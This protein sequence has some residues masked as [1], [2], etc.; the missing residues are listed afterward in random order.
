MNSKSFEWPLELNHHFVV[1][2]ASHRG[3]CQLL[4]PKA[5]LEK[6]SGCRAY[7]EQRLMPN[8]SNKG[9]SNSNAIYGINTGFGSLATTS[10]PAD[11]LLQLQLNLV[12]SHACGLGEPL[13][14]EEAKAVL[15]LRLH[16]LLQGHSGVTLGLIQR[17]QHLLETDYIPVI[18]QL[19]SVGA[20][21]DLAPLAHMA[22]GI[23][24]EGEFYEDDDDK[25]VS[26]RGH[27]QLKEKEGL[28]LI[29]GTS[30]HTAL[31]L[32]ALD[33]AQGL[34]EQALKTAALSIDALQ[35]STAPFH[36]FIQSVK[37]HPGQLK[38]A[39][40]VKELLQGSGILQHHANCQRVQ[41]PYSLRCLPQVMGAVAQTLEHALQV[42]TIEAN[43]ITD[44]PLIDA[45]EGLI[46][47]G[48]NFHG[49]APALAMDYA[50]MG[51][52]ELASIV[53]RRIDKMMNPAFSSLPAF[54]AADSG[55][56]SGLMMAQVSASALASECKFLA[57][58]ASIDNIPTSNDKED[59]V[60][61]GP[62]AAR[63]WRQIN[64]LV[65]KMLGLEALAASRAI[66]L[67][68]PLQSSEALEQFKQQIDNVTAQVRDRRYLAGQDRPLQREVEALAEYFLKQS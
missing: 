55:L 30:M 26:Q 2:L 19:G 32:L 42:L 68:R 57:H 21:G 45:E 58:P 49:Q 66:D 52:S 25:E 22:L 59:H 33:Q 15:I 67:L 64:G 62:L 54:L 9:N 27:Y 6:V 8:N 37:P 53:E 24:G 47:S 11:Q 12:R 7:L 20:S 61:M 29:N 65:A 5:L 38:A 56:E 23:I 51:M 63:K 18:P 35:G 41:D 34:W 60:S 14:R 13:R 10:I 39:K 44:N 48:G 43:S 31:G 16:C 3:P 50:A 40:I 17:M 1:A 4:L 36:F 28:A 46:I